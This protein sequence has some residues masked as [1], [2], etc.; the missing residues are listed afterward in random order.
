MLEGGTGEET[1]M[2]EEIVRL[3]AQIGAMKLLLGRAYTLLYTLAK[4]APRTSEAGK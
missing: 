4:M 1:Q 3:L 2:G